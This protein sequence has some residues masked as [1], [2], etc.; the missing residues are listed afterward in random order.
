MSIRIHQYVAVVSAG[1]IGAGVTLFLQDPSFSR[2][3]ARAA[4]TFA[5]ISILTQALR[6]RTSSESSGS[7]S[8]IPLL[9]SA[10]IAPHWMC[11]VSVGLSALTAQIVTKKTPL[12]ALFNTAQSILSISLGIVAYLAMGGRPLHNIGESGSLSLFALFLVFSLTNSIC[13]AGAVGLVSGRPSWAIWKENTLSALPYDFLSL[14]VILFFVWIY[15][16]YD[17]VGAFVLAVPLL[18]LR[19]LYKVN[20]QLEQTNRE[21]LELMVA[22][23]EARDP[24][25][26]GHSRRVAEK[27]RVIAR[28]VGLRD[29]EVE[30]IVA[31][32]LLHDVGKIHEVF[33]PILSKPGRLTPEEQ[34]IMRTHPVKSAELAG[35]VTQ[36]RD[37]VPLIRHHHENWDGTGYPDGLKEGDI[38]LGSRI[39]M[40]ADTID[41]MT[42]DRPYRAALDATSVRKEL[43]R[44]RGTQFD[45]HICDAL[46]RSPEYSKLFA[47]TNVGTEQ[48][49]PQTPERG[50]VLRTAVS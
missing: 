12:K 39:I 40:F 37:V 38:P 24:Y 33:G 47:P 25:T 13:V 42:T 27:T 45:P 20:W 15:T 22:A 6:Y 17:V 2:E 28:A 31:A 26:S 49:Q 21:L 11:V 43:L 36:L 48:W 18:G 7:L 23:I 1:A 41:A 9:A 44:F 46:L 34:V 5:L 3:Y 35:T 50:S 16:Q 10:A 29:K 4:I 19:Q 32:A 30:R 14:P 8:F